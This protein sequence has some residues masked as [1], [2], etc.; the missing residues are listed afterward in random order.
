MTYAL[1]TWL[2]GRLLGA[3]FVIAF[4]SFWVQLDGLI[5]S[6]GITPAIDQ[7]TNIDRAL[8]E[9]AGWRVPTLAWLDAS[10]GALVAMAALGTGCAVLLT[11][12]VMP[13]PALAICVATYVSLLNVGGPFM[14][15]Q[16]DTL[17]IET[18]FAS[19]LLVPLTRVH[20]RHQPHEPPPLARWL[21]YAL[22]AKLMFLSGWVKL[23][24]QDPTWADLTALAVHYET[25]PLPNPVSHWMHFQPLWFHRASCAAMFVIEF[26]APIAALIPHRYARRAAA[27]SVS[28]LMG[29]IIVTGNYGFFNLLVIALCVPLL[30][31]A[32]LAKILR[33]PAHPSRKRRTSRLGSALGVMAATL[34][35]A[36]WS[37]VAPG[38]HT[39]R[40]T[41]CLIGF[42]AAAY[43]ARR[44]KRRL[45]KRL[46]QDFQRRATETLAVFFLLGSFIAFE[47]RFDPDG[48]E[49]AH[50]A[51]EDVS[52]LHIFNGYGLFARMTTNRAEVILEGSRDGRTWKPYTLPYQPGP[53][54]RA[55]PVVLGHMPRL[56]WQMWFA[57]LSSRGHNP[58]VVS[59]MHKLLE[60]E[61]A[62]LR[63]FEH[64]PFAD[65]PPVWIRARIYDYRFSA[66]EGWW[67][68]GE[69]RVY[70]PPMSAAR[71]GIH[72]GAV[73]H[74]DG[75]HGHR[76][77]AGRAPVVVFDGDVELNRQTHVVDAVGRAGE[78]PKQPG[79]LEP[80]VFG[81]IQVHDAA[82]RLTHQPAV[83]GAAAH[84]VTDE[85]LIG[86]TATARGE[87]DVKAP[88]R[89]QRDHHLIARRNGLELV[90]PHTELHVEVTG[91]VLGTTHRGRRRFLR[92][93]LPRLVTAARQQHRGQNGR[94]SHAPTEP[95][96]GRENFTALSTM[97][98]TQGRRKKS[99]RSFASR[100]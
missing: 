12:G 91:A 85:H 51:L 77:D 3:V 70:V 78:E 18:G 96:L 36:L 37:A 24:S 8:G 40:I 4:V 92:W 83:V 10:D 65:A 46:L 23:A 69:P 26:A 47:A 88:L 58:W 100:M 27:V 73:P 53:L 81:G 7:L 14:R 49:F 39:L 87:P 11:V 75:A 66:E 22:L 80:V 63:L 68:R 99:S 2:Y 13:A 82:E 79:D 84:A 28:L 95:S 25:Q 30:D 90:Q 19:L 29:V 41:L 86:A 64:N 54:D 62:V 72:L 34:V 43:F 15:F 1:S 16:W 76:Q 48:R 89:S 97:R 5:G 21:L 67:E 33:A 98:F 59:L 17:L 74:L 52:G 57:A 44:Q 20:E 94:S 31:D 6:D 56:D 32:L 38:E 60:A 35:V 71:L 42:G 50:E 9:E 55:P 61:P 45:R 93:S